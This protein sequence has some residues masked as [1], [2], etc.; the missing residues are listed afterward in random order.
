MRRQITRQA[1]DREREDNLLSRCCQ[2]CDSAHQAARRRV[3]NMRV[4]RHH[5]EA[6]SE[7]HGADAWDNNPERRIHRYTGQDE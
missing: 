4:E 6:H 2:W 5:G 7:T 1:C 3:Q